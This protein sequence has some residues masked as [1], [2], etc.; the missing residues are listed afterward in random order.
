MRN[1]EVVQGTMFMW[2]FRS[3]VPVAVSAATVILIVSIE[4][5]AYAIVCFFFQHFFPILATPP[6]SH[7]L[8]HFVNSGASDAILKQ[9]SGYA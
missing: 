3:S 8:F 2:C 1:S 5:G 6:N 4:L 9:S 7:H